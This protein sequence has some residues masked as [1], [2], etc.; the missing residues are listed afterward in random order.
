[1]LRGALHQLAGRPVEIVLVEVDLGQRIAVMRVEA[2][3]NDDQV[4]P[5]I[6]ERRQD[7][8]VERLAEQVAAGA[9]RQRR[10]DDVAGAGLVLGAGAGIERHLV[11][12]AVEHRRVVPEDVLGAVAV[13]DVPVDDG[14]PLGAVL[15]LR[16]AGG[17]R[18]IVEQA[19]THR[20]RALGVV[21]GR[22]RRD[23]DVVGRPRNRRRRP[24]RS[25]L[26]PPST[27][28]PS[29]SGSSRYRRRCA[30]CRSRAPPSRSRST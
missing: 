14:D 9:G 18:G 16:M 13:M 27:Q 23:E 24:R 29:S 17:D 26:R 20:G 7:A 25:P 4:G 1:M 22:P 3:G 5:E 2:G 6:V 19:K 30:R 8:R 15:L 12:R 10:V 11:G 21:A 28:P